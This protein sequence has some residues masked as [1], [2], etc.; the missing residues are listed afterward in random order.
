M[1]SELFPTQLVGSYHK[2][3]WLADHSKVYTKEGGWWRVKPDQ[4][5]AA[6]GDAVRL[7]VFDQN[8]AG[9][10]YATDGEQ[11]RQTFSGHFNILGGID[12]D[13]PL[14]FTNFHND[15]TPYL[16]M[17]QMAKGVGADVKKMPKRQRRRKFCFRRFVHL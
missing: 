10:S 2:P 12:S 16:E 7:A 17:R 5:E 9:M 8:R 14:Q 11:R 15:I 1:W 4:L 13:N 6:Q 3:H